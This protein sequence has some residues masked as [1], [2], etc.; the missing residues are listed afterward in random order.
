MDWGIVNQVIVIGR[1]DGDSSLYLDRRPFVLS[2]ALHVPDDKGHEGLY[3]R[4]LKRGN[5]AVDCRPASG[6]AVLVVGA[7]RTSIVALDGTPSAAPISWIQALSVRRP[8][9]EGPYNAVHLLGKVA[10]EVQVTLDTRQHPWATFLLAVPMPPWTGVYS[11]LVKVAVCGEGMV[12]RYVP[13]VEKGRYCLCR[14]RLIS[15]T[16]QGGKSD[17]SVLAQEISF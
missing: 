14:G 2:F 12:S 6:Q 8:Q 15:R 4:I 5:D 1:V 13:A 16:L 17:V 9:V 7:L 10:S 11:S 3:V